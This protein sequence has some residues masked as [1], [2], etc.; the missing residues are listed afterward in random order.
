MPWPL[1]PGEGLAVFQAAGFDNW[2]A[3]LSLQLFQLGR[4]DKLTSVKLT[5]S[6]ALGE[7]LHLFLKLAKP[8]SKSSR[9]KELFSPISR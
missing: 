4:E 9:K 5:M 3:V 6:L 2:A 8:H 1:S 7:G